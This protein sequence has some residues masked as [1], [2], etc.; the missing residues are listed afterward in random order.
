MNFLVLLELVQ[1][2]RE[3]SCFVPI[4]LIFLGV[5]RLTLLERLVVIIIVV[6]VDSLIYFLSFRACVIHE[7]IF[8]LI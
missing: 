4:F 6:A 2:S 1:H 5:F 3:D 8:F 7:D